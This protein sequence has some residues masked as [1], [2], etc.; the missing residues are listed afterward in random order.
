MGLAKLR[1]NNFEAFTTATDESTTNES[2]PAT[3]GTETNETNSSTATTT[4]DSKEG[5][6]EGE[7]EDAKEEEAKEE[8]EG[9][10][11]GEGEEEEEEAKEEEA[12]EEEAK[13]EE[14]ENK[15]TELSA[16]V[17]D[18]FKKANL[19]I[20]A[21]FLVVYV[22]VFIGFGMYLKQSGKDGMEGTIS[23]T[24]DFV[25]FGCTI[26]Y[27][28]Y[29][30][31][32][33]SSSEKENSMKN[34]VDGTIELYDDDQSLFS[35]MLFVICFYVL[36][37]LLRVPLRSHKPMSVVFIEGISWLLLA[38]LLIHNCLKYFFNVDLLDKI[39]D[40]DISVLDNVMGTDE[41][42]DASGNVIDTSG[43]IVESPKEEVVDETP[44]VFNI[45]NNLYKYDDAQ[46][47]CRSYD[48]RLATYDEIEKA[49]QNGAEWC[50]YGWSENQMAFFPTQKKT[51]NELQQSEKHKN[52]CGR[53]GVNG[54]YFRNPNI[55]FGVNCFGKKPKA[56]DNDLAFMGTRKDRPYP[57][58]EEERKM[59]EKVDY[60]KKHAQDMLRVSSFNRDK[61]SRY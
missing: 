45:S 1:Y 59:D 49:Y 36:L 30:Y 52:S 7:G 6:G 50:N 28:I 8:G 21:G 53:P 33:M 38:T 31:M 25:F 55:K 37:F 48:A 2:N 17:T 4:E 46:A 20:L 56:K 54:G 9:E 60:W 41:E 57:K 5:E 42:V 35:L 44:E 40:A 58:T 19:Y 61:W 22:V 13:E 23:S 14:P 39:R 12:K 15:N 29:K 34:I 47:I 11:E 32:T 10:G 51:W 24:F 27:G 18:I 16:T 3:G 26:A 43:N